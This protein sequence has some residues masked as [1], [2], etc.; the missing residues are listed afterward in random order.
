MI[1]AY[2]LALDR[3]DNGYG[4]SYG[5]QELRDAIADSESSKGWV[6]KSEDV[7]VTHGVTEA[8]QNFILCFPRIR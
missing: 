4:P 2:K 8:L 1:S 7:Y 5:I 3:Q 6:C